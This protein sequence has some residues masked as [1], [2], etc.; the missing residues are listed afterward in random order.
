MRKLLHITCLT[1]F[2]ML[3][4]V[5][6]VGQTVVEFDATKDKGSKTTNSQNT[7]DDS[8]TKDG[9]T[10]EGK[11]QDSPV[12]IPIGFGLPTKENP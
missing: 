4:A 6:A 7:G 9:V 2:A 3:F 8:V 5:T 11:F 1:L 10:I 12:R